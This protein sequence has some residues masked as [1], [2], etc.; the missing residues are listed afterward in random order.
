MG[1]GERRDEPKPSKTFDLTFEN[2]RGR[3]KNEQNTL[4]NN[5]L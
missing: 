2:R 1:G 4:P 3:R 5:L